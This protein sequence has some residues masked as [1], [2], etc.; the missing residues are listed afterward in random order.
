MERKKVVFKKYV[1]NQAVMFPPSLEEMIPEK[2]PVRV[3]NDIVERIEIGELEKSYKG[4]GA[5]SYHPRMLLKVL[6]Y[7][8][9]R[10]VYSSR[11]IEAALT[12]NVHFMWLSGGAK[13]DHN[14]I[15]DFRSKRLAGQLKGIFNRVVMLLAEEGVV[16]L[17]ELTV[18]GTKIE[19]N[20]NRYT[21]VW[22][23]AIKV[24]RERIEKQL[25]ELWAYVEKVYADE[26][27]QPNAPEFTGLDARAVEK[28]IEEINE[29]LK[30][31]EIEPKVRQKLI[32]A[33]K[34]WPKKLAEY[35][36][37]EKILKDRK[38]YS[39]TDEDAT[40][41][42]MKEDHMR[43]GQLK[44]G[45]NLQASTNGHYIVNYTLGQKTNDTSLLGE[46]LREHEAGY[47][48]MPETLTADAGYGSEENYEYLEKKGIKAFVK[49]NYFEKETTDKKHQANPFIADNLYYNE[50]DD[51]YYC[52]SGQ[53]MK[54]VK[55]GRQTTAGG[56]LQKIKYYQAANCELCPMRGPCHRSRGNR[57][58][59]RNENVI[60]HRKKAR[61]LLESEEGVERRR[62][63]WKVEAV[64]GNIKH[65]KN[66][67]RFMLRGLDKV[68]VE[69]GLIA[70]AHNLQRFAAGH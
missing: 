46:H 36:G 68:S 35:D 29:A 34:N 3:V 69:T 1:Q 47:G 2:H 31:K 48:K 10:N 11:K 12:E 50:K 9:L 5:S 58:I 30:K 13:P 21:F 14:T 40:F 17:R 15:S 49:Y 51:I 8:Y 42:R 20:A 55:I 39:K 19:A 43:N 60:R 56:Y 37:K 70:L 52:P 66:F 26:E 22:G 4:G 16:T 28:A 61:E 65:N 7:A 44:P 64:F 45:Y 57:I 32:Y 41:M 59:Q 62:Q 25:R 54:L 38:S 53:P 24:S 18:D 23:R 33:K 67:K 63:R 27:N 6:I